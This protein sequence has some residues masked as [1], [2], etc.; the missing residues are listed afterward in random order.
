MF[1]GRETG[2]CGDIVADVGLHVPR[3]GGGPYALACVCR[4]IRRWHRTRE[5]I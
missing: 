3:R 4:M 5:A 2:C 1:F